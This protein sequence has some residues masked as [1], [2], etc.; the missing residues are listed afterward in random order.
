MENHRNRF[1]SETSPPGNTYPLSP[2]LHKSHKKIRAFYSQIYI[3]YK[4][5]KYVI[6]ELTSL[7]ENG[8]SK[9]VKNNILMKLNNLLALSIS[10]NQIG[11]R[12]KV[13]GNGL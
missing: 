8:N 1:L 13:H 2:G 3:F 11:N 5:K 9:Q 7:M 6:K 12:Q 10:Y 4:Q